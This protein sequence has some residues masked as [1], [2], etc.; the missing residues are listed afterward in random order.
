[1]TRLR[2]LWLHL[3]L[4]WHG[5]CPKHGKSLEWGLSCAR[6]MDQRD[7]RAKIKTSLLL[8]ELRRMNGGRR[9]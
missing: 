1:V 8:A 9:G 7:Y 5:V 3:R 2:K 6:C 4:L